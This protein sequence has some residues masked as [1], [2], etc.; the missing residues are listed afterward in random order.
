MRRIGLRYFFPPTVLDIDDKGDRNILVFMT[1]WV[2]NYST[3]HK[4]PKRMLKLDCYNPF[5]GQE[6]FENDREPWAVQS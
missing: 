1:G 4:H 2:N 3:C 6:G 5:G